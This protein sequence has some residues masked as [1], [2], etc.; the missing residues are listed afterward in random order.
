MKYINSVSLETGT[1][2]HLHLVV[3]LGAKGL[4]ELTHALR[5]L[6]VGHDRQLALDDESRITVTLDEPSENARMLSYV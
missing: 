3:V 4:D 5:Q 6:A 1:T 2:A